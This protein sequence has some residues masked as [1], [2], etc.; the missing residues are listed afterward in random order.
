MYSR[1]GRLAYLVYIRDF[2][3]EVPSK[4][5]IPVVS[6]FPEVFHT[7][8]RGTAPDRDIN[9][10][11][12]LVPDTHPTSIPLYRMAPVESKELKDQLQDLLDKGFIRPSFS[13]WSAQIVKTRVS[14]TA[15]QRPIPQDKAMKNGSG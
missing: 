12:D 3:V 7:D 15:E 14:A 6:E 9:F 11:I 2:I 5:S 4:Y 10:C 13:P 1:E 8:F